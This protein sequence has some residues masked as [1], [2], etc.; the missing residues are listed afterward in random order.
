MPTFD[1]CAA[2]DA[3]PVNEQ[4]VVRQR[5][6]QIHAAQRLRGM[7][8]RNDSVLTYK[9]GVGEIED[10]PSAIANELVVV[11]QI[12]KGTKYC[13]LVEHVMRKI[14]LSLKN[15]YNLTWTE[16]W[17]VTRMYGPSMLKLYCIKRTTGWCAL[18]TME[19]SPHLYE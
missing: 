3:V 8:P 12:H 9:Y 1:L 2:I 4:A 13:E 14:A 15:M 18:P 7:E 11:D 6:N 17:A 10:V 5:V 16:A 19:A